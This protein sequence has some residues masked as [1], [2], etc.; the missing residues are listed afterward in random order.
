MD[1]TPTSVAAVAVGPP[2]KAMVQHYVDHCTIAYMEMAAALK[3][4][5]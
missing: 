2:W 1:A 3:R 5:I 4:L